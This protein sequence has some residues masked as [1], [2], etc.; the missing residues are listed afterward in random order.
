MVEAPGLW[1]A[2][3][4]V[5][6]H[7]LSTSACEIFP[8]QS[9]TSVFCI[10]REILHHWDKTEAPFL[11]FKNMNSTK[12][13][14]FQNQKLWTDNKYSYMMITASSSCLSIAV[15]RKYSRR[16]QKHRQQKWKTDKLC[17]I[18]N[19]IICFKIRPLKMKR[20]T[21]TSGIYLQCIYLAM[22]LY[23]ECVHTFNN[24]KSNKKWTNKKSNKKCSKH[25][26]RNFMKGDMCGQ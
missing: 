1:S 6:V 2:V 11:I 17:F 4:V 20:Q 21:K 10:G 5:M 15:I 14:N 18:K 23:L 8:N 13:E 9:W 24:M 12:F 16:H 7:G 22:D 19:N 3:S 25:L 26:N